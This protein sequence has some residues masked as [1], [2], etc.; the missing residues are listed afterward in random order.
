MRFASG[1]GVWPELAGRHLDGVMCLAREEEWRMVAVMQPSSRY[2][3]LT[4]FQPELAKVE[5]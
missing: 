5:G 2:A 1:G 3:M 4:C